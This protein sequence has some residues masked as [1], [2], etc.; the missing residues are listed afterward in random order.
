MAKMTQ[1]QI[2]ASK[3]L[4]TESYLSKK[5]LEQ[6]Y[7]NEL[8]EG[9]K[10]FH[11]NHLPLYEFLLDKYNVQLTW[12]IENDCEIKFAFCFQNEKDFCNSST[13]FAKSILGN[14]LMNDGPYV[15]GYLIDGVLPNLSEAELALVG[16]SML[17]TSAILDRDIPDCIRREFKKFAE[18]CPSAYGTCIKVTSRE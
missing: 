12:E 14:R 2:E 3:K 15:F 10:Y 18:R 1:E 5:K 11:E 4:A 9:M 8:K 7:R 16:R 17:T 6:E 13:K